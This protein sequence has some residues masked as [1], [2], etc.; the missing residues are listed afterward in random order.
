MKNILPAP[1]AFYFFFFAAFAAMSPFLALYYQGLGFSGSQIG[2]LLGISPLISLFASTFWTGL[3]DARH[4]HKVVLL[5]T[6]LMTILI[7]AIFPFLKTFI[8]VLAFVLFLSFASASIISL[9]DTATISMLGEHREFYGRTR[10]WGTIGWGVS[11]SL[12]GIFFQ[13]SGLH[14]LFW[15]YALL[16]VFTLFAV[17]RIT[18]S[19][20]ISA[21]LFWQGLRTVFTDRR[22]VFFL[23]II[24]VAGVG[25]AVHSNYVSLLFQHLGAPKTFVGFAVTITMLSELPILF[26][27]NRLLR[28]F[29]PNRLLTLATIFIGLRCLFYAF[30]STPLVILLIQLLHGLTYPTLWVAGVTY[31]AENAP[32]GLEA[33][34]QGILASVLTGFGMSAGGLLGGILIDSFGIS[35]MYLYVGLIVLSATVGFIILQNLFQ[36]SHVETL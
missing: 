2:F 29:K 25:T 9:V 15:I 30:S 14:W 4:R 20:P 10:L 23:F 11:A 3:A 28:W 7:A 13:A 12:A 26:F 35:R 36:P 18:F 31:A 5:T 16:M 19:H 17:P 22:W 33:T 6:I 34:S 1:A 8:W 27:S 21:V 24:F 32:P